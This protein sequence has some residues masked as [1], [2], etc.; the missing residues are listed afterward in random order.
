MMQKQ[1]LFI[2]DRKEMGILILLGLT[3]AVFAFTLGVHL[4]K[5]VGPKMIADAH[6]ASEVVKTEKDLN[7]NRQELTEQSE[8]IQQAADET[9]NQELHD[10]VARSGIRLDVARQVDLPGKSKS[11]NGGATTSAENQNNQVLME[12][13]SLVRN[14][15]DGNYTLQI[16][17]FSA[18]NEAKDRIESLQALGLKPFVRA[19]EVKGKG[20]WF[21]VCLG[22]FES[23]DSAEQAGEKFISQH[24]VDSFI[25]QKLAE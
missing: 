19:A 9:L 3:V 8:G 13:P 4:G 22:G 15:P 25:V 23:K 17:S 7:P 10:E 5:K 6:S 12:F 14:V 16:G 11:K 2:Y 24:L 21:R 20:Q 1:R 18:A